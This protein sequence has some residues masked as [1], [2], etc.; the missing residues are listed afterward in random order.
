MAFPQQVQS[1][2]WNLAQDVPQ[3]QI[4][5]DDGLDVAAARFAA[6]SFIALRHV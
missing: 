1:L 4:R 5:I 3:V 2:Q 6:V